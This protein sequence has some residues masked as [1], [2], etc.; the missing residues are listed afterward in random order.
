ML[1]GGKPNTENLI[2]VEEWCRITQNNFWLTN[3]VIWKHQSQIYPSLI[4][5]MNL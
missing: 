4:F 5:L 3:L 2:S 1:F